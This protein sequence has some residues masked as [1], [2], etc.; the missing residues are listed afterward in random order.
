MSVTVVICTYKRPGVAAR[1]AEAIVPQLGPE[2]SCLVVAQG[3]DAEYEETRGAIGRKFK[4]PV[5]SLRIIHQR[6]PS[7]TEARNRGLVEAETAYVAYLD[8]DCVARPGWLAELLVPLREGRADLV[9]GRLVEDPD[10]TTNAPRRTGAVITSTGH[11]RRNFN[12]PR[13]GPSGLAPG[14]NMAVRRELALRVGGFDTGIWRGTATYE[15]SEF[16]ERLR[17]AGARI[18]YN[19]EAVV[20]HLAVRSGSWWTGDLSSQEAER[21]RHMSLIF[22]RHRPWRWPL[23]AKAYILAAL[24]KVVRGRLPYRAVRMVAA[25]L[26]EGRGDG[27]REMRPLSERTES[28]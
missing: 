14:G 8:D 28:V 25:G 19:G 27:A 3:D 10:L 15:D 16:S 4:E 1:C 6:E 20:D 13:S 12:T 5:R 7:R 11:T 9:A 24:F 23:M 22:R 18:W 17:R 21:A 26:I 2:D